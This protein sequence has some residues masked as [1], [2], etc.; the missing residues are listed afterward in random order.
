MKY[1]WFE[2]LHILF[3]MLLEN[4]Q[5]EPYEQPENPAF[6]TFSAVEMSA[7]PNTSLLQAP[8]LPTTVPSLTG[9]VILSLPKPALFQ[10]HLSL[11]IVRQK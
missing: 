10:Y 5:Y 8:A 9:A 4:I 6:S 11:Q 3:R 1:Q 2:F 7:S